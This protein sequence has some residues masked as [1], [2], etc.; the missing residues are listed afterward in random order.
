MRITVHHW[1]GRPGA[2]CFHCGA[3]DPCEKAVALGWI[4]FGPDTEPISFDTPEHE[5]AVV[6]ANVC[7]GYSWLGCGGSLGRD[8][9]QCR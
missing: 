8:C 1:T 7:P 2:V 5:A 3:E 6:A 4:V 9:P